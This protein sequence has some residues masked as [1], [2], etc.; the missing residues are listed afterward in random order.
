MAEEAWVLLVQ[1]SVL[2]TTIFAHVKSPVASLCFVC[3]SV[4]NLVSVMI[5]VLIFS[6]P[7][8]PSACDMFATLISD[9]LCISLVNLFVN[10]ESVDVD[11]RAVQPRVCL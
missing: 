1:D 10:L 8:G 9:L 2:K 6:A 11:R 4:K 7:P 3:S 5:S